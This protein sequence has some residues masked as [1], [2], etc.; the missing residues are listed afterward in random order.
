MKF[1]SIIASSEEGS[2]L[3]GGPLP[4]LFLMFV[5][6]YFLLI[7]PQSKAK[8]EQAA[9]IASLE[10][11]DKV[12]TI[13]GLHGTVHHISKTTATVKISEGVFVPFEK[14]AIRSVTKVGQGKKKS[15]QEEPEEEESPADAD[16]E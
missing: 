5:I 1:Y 10:K 8:K 9:R 14:D 3:L 16:Q 13:G 2:S 4:M 12:I 6:M 7:R 15:P 11:G